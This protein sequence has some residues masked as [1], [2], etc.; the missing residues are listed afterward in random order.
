M[1]TEQEILTSTLVVEFD[2]DGT[3]LVYDYSQLRLAQMKLAEAVYGYQADLEKRPPRSWQEK[4]QLGG[5]DYDLTVLSYILLKKN[6]DGSLQPFKG[7]ETQQ[8]ILRLVENIRSA[9][10]EK[11]ERVIEDFFE[12]RGQYTLALLVRSKYSRE[13]GAMFA[14]MIQSAAVQAQKQE[15]SNEN[16][17]NES[18]ATTD[19]GN[20]ESETDDS[21]T[22]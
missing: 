13:F 8:P 1:S 14:Q 4:V 9:D 17:E 12:R 16:S 22:V 21:S 5:A 2:V 19:S 18:N 3:T 15:T 7:G 20:P 10:S 11:V 6:P